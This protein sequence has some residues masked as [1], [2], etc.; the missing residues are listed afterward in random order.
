MFLGLRYINNRAH[1]RVDTGRKSCHWWEC[2]L[3]SVLPKKPLVFQ[4]N[5]SDLKIKIHTNT[6]THTYKYIHMQKGVGVGGGATLEIQ[7]MEAHS[8]HNNQL[9]SATTNWLHVRR[10][11][12]L[13]YLFQ[14]KQCSSQVTSI[15]VIQSFWRE[16]GREREVFQISSAQRKCFHQ[17]M[18]CFP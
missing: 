13:K 10:V 4:V 12:Y 11:C 15:G 17:L 7:F 14:R 5:D 1:K 2:V 9:F 18:S 6:N 16:R 8:G 3:L